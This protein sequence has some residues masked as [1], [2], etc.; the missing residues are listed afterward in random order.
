LIIRDHDL[1]ESGAQVGRLGDH[2]DARF[3]SILAGDDPA[4]VVVVDLD[5][6]A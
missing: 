4:D 5:R 1:G 3:R 6:D 2:P